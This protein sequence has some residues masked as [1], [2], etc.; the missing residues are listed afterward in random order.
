ME[1]HSTFSNPSG[2]K[3]HPVTY[4]SCG[5]TKV[6]PCYKTCDP[7]ASL[8]IRPLDRVQ[9]SHPF[10]DKTCEMDGA[11]RIM[12]SHPS[13]KN[14]DVARVG[15][16]EMIAILEGR[17]DSKLKPVP[18]KIKNYFASPSEFQDVAGSRNRL[19]MPP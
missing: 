2:A 11:R 5:L 7:Q 15:H 9:A 4:C 13:D 6:R 3:A 1:Q 18:F 12:L 10:R 19:V 16:P 14:K 8:S 17:T